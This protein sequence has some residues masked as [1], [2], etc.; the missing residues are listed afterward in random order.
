MSEG[1]AGQM[2]EPTAPATTPTSTS[3]ESLSLLSVI[4]PAKDEEGCIAS[5]EEHLFVALRLQNVP[6]E[7]VVIGDG[8]T[9]GTWTA[10]VNAQARIPTLM[11]VQNRGLHGF[12]RAIVYGLNHSM[13]DAI[14]IMMADRSDD[15][16]DVVMYWKGLNEGL[17]VPQFAQ[18][19]IEQTAW[20]LNT[21][22]GSNC[23]DLSRR[24]RNRLIGSHRGHIE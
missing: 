15:C 24:H 5:T 22:G 17:E 11:P 21:R 7:L 3:L 8:S 10:L 6:H 4:I 18:P 16:H 20:R 14:V 1:L 2:T 19:E 9:E 12:G 23:R 13:G